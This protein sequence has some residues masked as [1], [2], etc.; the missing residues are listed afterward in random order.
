MRIDE[1][2][3]KEQEMSVISA[4]EKQVTM[5]D[6][7]TGIETKVPRDP[8]KPGVIQKDPKDPSGKKFIVDP[9]ATGEVDGDIQP[10]AMVTMK[11]GM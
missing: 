6:P 11:T 4:D 3:I 2:I 9:G 1:I 8:K 5:K 10:G 7:K